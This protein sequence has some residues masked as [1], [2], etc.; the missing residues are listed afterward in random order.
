[1][2]EG[3]REDPV[4]PTGHVVTE[5]PSFNKPWT[6]WF[7][8]LTLGLFLGGTI[9]AMLPVWPFDRFDY[10]AIQGDGFITLNRLLNSWPEGL[11]W[12]L[13]QLGDAAVLIPLLSPIV[14]LRPQAWAA[15]LAAA[16][17]ASLFSVT[18]KHLAAVPRPAAYLDPD[19]F[20]R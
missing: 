12:N 14:L 18:F 15:A 11:W 8:L 10:C 5:H 16:P 4:E 7:P 19:Q 9:L 20:I 3:A 6:V 13:T 17:V 2:S 1:M